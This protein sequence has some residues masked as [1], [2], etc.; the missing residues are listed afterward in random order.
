MRLMVPSPWGSIF[1]VQPLTLVNRTLLLITG[2]LFALIIS[3]LMEKDM[4]KI[5]NKEIY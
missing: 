3:W 4:Q 1:P 5:L 2:T